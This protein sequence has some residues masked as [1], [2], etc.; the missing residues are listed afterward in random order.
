MKKVLTGGFLSLVGTFWGI[1]IL[2]FARDNLAA[3]WSTP[4][5]RLLTTIIENGLM[6]PFALSIAVA[7]L[8]S[9]IMMVESF[10]K[11]SD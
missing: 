1:T 2:N 3:G 7:L 4:P 6:V 10:K 9:V 5:G 8:G 11:N